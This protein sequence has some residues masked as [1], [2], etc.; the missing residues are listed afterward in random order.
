MPQG[1]G[2]A[3]APRSDP[4]KRGAASDGGAGASGASS[5]SDGSSSGG[6]GGGSSGAAP[7]FSVAPV[8]ESAPRRSWVAKE[9]WLDLDGFR[10]LLG[11]P[12]YD[13]MLGC[14][15]WR[16]AS[17]LVFP[18]SRQGARAVQSVEV[19]AARR[20][21]PGAAAQQGASLQQGAQQQGGIGGEEA[22]GGR[23]YRFTFC[24][25]RVESGGMKGCWL[26]VGV[27][28]GDYSL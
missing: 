4:R 21:A 25:E 17:P 19:V 10:R 24:L 3:A 5:S 27:R 28:V 11:A 7:L 26:T 12:P 13:V 18:G 20:P 8:P 16:P 22:A 15:S 1:V 14:D 9:E 23:T 6:S 2:G